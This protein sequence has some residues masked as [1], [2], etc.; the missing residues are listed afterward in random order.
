MSSPRSIARAAACGYIPTRPRC[1]LHTLNLRRTTGRVYVASS[2][3]TYVI[4]EYDLNIERIADLFPDAEILAAR[5]LF[6]SNA[7]WLKKWPGIVSQIDSLIFFEDADG[8]IGYGVWTEINDAT[9][10]G[11]PVYFLMDAAL[12]PWSTVEISERRPTNWWQYARLRVA[13]R[14][15]SGH[16]G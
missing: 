6:S 14:V 7:D 15:G 13:W 9:A 8:Y 2:L 1:L 5:A 16:D 12:H 10:H 11:I 3:S 4:P